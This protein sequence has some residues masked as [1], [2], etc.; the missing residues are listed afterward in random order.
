MLHH[1]TLWRWVVRHFQQ[2]HC[3]DLM[4]GQWLNVGAWGRYRLYQH[5]VVLKLVV[6]RFW[7]NVNRC[8]LLQKFCVL[9][10]RRICSSWD[11]HSESLMLFSRRRHTRRFKHINLNNIKDR[12]LRSW[13]ST[14]CWTRWTP[15]ALTYRT[16]CSF[17]PCCTFEAMHYTFPLIARIHRT[18][19]W[20]CMRQCRRV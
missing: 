18:K 1:E 12:C 3:V 8:F 2:A 17:L 16:Y 13:L 20:A 7:A 5:T 11:W 10:I 15:P 14:G 9:R 4:I 19:S 6:V